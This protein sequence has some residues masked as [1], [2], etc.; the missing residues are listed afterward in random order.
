VRLAAVDTWL[1]DLDN[2]LYPPSAGLFAQIDLRM[3]AYV[4]RLLGI[5]RDAARA[6][7]KR[8]FHEHGTTL[9]G[10][11]LSHAIDPYHF[12]ADVHAI[13]LGA[14]RPD[15]GLAA[16]LASLPGR[17][18]VFTN[19]DAAYAARVIEARG[20]GGIFEAIFDVEAAGWH[21]KPD[22]RA[23]AGLCRRHGVDPSRSLFADDMA[24]NLKPAADMGMLT[25]WINNG[26]ERGAHAAS[27]EFIDFETHDIAAWL[28]EFA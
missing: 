9:R 20:L 27:A 12:L 22:A 19:A 14:L 4:A 25:L 26:S 5:G 6:V 10:L 7:Q 13:D 18:F 1:F 17:R 24:Y 11:M 28:E 16:R 8:Y 15:P 21:P 3:E 2:S 23:Y